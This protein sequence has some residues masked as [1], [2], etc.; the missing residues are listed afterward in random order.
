ML[1]V[2]NIRLENWGG[3]FHSILIIKSLASVRAGLFILVLRQI[4]CLKTLKNEMQRFT[5]SYRKWALFYLIF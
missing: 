2:Q 4:S 1:S 3:N 5:D